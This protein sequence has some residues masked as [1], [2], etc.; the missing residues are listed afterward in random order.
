MIP[1]HRAIPWS[2][3]APHFLLSFALAACA[4]GPPKSAAAPAAETS[5]NG[6]RLWEHERSDIPADPRIHFGR[7]ASGMRYAWVKNSE[8]KERCCLRLHEI[9]R[10]HV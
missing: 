3:R 6:A 9:G 8:P 1:P 4:S 5:A 2:R 7:L 10:A